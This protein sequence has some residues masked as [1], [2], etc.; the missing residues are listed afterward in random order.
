MFSNSTIS[1]EEFYTYLENT[2]LLENSPLDIPLLKVSDV[3]E[4]VKSLSEGIYTVDNFLPS[5]QLA[6]MQF[7]YIQ[8]TPIILGLKQDPYYYKSYNCK[9][10]ICFEERVN[11]WRHVLPLD[12]VIFPVPE[13]TFSYDAL[14]QQVGVYKNP[15]IF[16]L[17]L[18]NGNRDEQ[19]SVKKRACRGKYLTFLS[20]QK[21]HL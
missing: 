11:L 18:D 2:L 16:H 1:A 8:N 3:N 17:T 14:S 15:K 9:S 19:R 6:L 13:L 4:Y 7:L 12:S 10:P 5:T 21:Q 20:L